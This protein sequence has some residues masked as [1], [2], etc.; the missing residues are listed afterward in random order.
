MALDLPIGDAHTWATALD[1][2]ELKARAEATRNAA[3][4]KGTILEEFAAWLLPH[5][6]GLSVRATNTYSFGR[7]SEVDL[8]VWN[9]QHEAGFRSIDPPILVECKN[10]HEAVGAAEVAWFDWKMRL[11]GAT[12]GLLFTANGITGDA[13]EKNA[14]YQ[15]IQTARTERRT[16]VVLTL[17]ELATQR[18]AEDLRY[19]IIDKICLATAAARQTV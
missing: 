17:D 7:A 3:A 16:M 4:D 19:L 1:G 9:E 13:T 11:G 8:T 6:P 15:I 14:A 12:H 10:W 18:S 5:I 2:D